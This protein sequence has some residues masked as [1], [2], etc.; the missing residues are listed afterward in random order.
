MHC[1]W[2]ASF[3]LSVVFLTSDFLMFVGCWFFL[4]G[5]WFSL[6]G[7]WL[8]VCFILLAVGCLLVGCCCLLAVCLLAVVG[9]WLFACWPLAAVCLLAVGC[10]RPWATLGDLAKP[11][12]HLK[13]A[14][15]HA[16]TMKGFGADLGVTLGF[17]GEGRASSS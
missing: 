3:D 12:L 8:F 17:P 1:K 4:V 9:C 6:V 5:C 2:Q 10:W 15:D 13:L 7:C 11:C 16:A 14:S